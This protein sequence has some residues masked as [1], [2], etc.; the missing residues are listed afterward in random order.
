MADTE[1][2]TVLLATD[3]SEHCTDA[4]RKA[5]ELLGRDHRFVT[6]AVV[7][8][9]FVPTASLSPMEVHPTLVDPELELQLEEEQRAVS[10]DEVH[11]LD[12]ALAITAE[13]LVETGEPG[14]T[15]CEVAERVEADVIV[16]GSHGHGR[17]K[18]ML[19][20]SVSTHVLHNARC[21]VLVVRFDDA[22]AE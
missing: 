7:P 1:P 13:H 21:P 12:A 3:G 19:M 18:R 16:V 17:F 2:K 8:P 20:G 5:V 14:D 10:D 22:D 4:L 9:A 11:H 6:L 15:V